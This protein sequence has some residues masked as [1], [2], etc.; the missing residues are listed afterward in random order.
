MCEATLRVS[1]IWVL[2]TQNFRTYSICRQYSCRQYSCGQYSCGQYSCGQYLK[3]S[4]FPLFFSI[5]KI[6]LL[7]GT[8]F[9]NYISPYLIY[10]NFCIFLFFY[11]LIFSPP[12][13]FTL[14]F[15]NPRFCW[16]FPTFF[17]TPTFFFPSLFSFLTFF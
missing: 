17:F 9:S 4:R 15:F 14:I 16:I 5:F 1:C 10:L 11:P 7:I 6:Y 2:Y 12:L 3:H 13:F 8:S